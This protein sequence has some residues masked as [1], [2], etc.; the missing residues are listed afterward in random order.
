MGSNDQR[1]KPWLEVDVAD[2]DVFVVSVIVVVTV[3]PVSVTKKMRRD[4]L[5]TTCGFNDFHMD[6]Q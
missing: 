1:P 2:V 6:F 4:S 5:P 3:V